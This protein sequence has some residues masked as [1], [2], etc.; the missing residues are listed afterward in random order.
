VST[1]NDQ[2]AIRLDEVAQILEEQ[3]ANPFRVRAYRRGAI[4]SGYCH[5]RSTSC[6][7]KAGCRRSSPSRAS[8]RAWPAPFATSS[9]P[10]GSTCSSD[11]GRRRPGN[12]PRHRSGHR[13]ENGRAPASRPRH[14]NA[15]GSRGCRHDGRLETLE[16]LV[17]SGWPGSG[18]RWR[19]TRSRYVRLPSRRLSNRPSPNCWTSTSSTDPSRTPAPCGW[20]HHA[21]STRGRGVAAHPAHAPRPSPLHGALLQHASRAPARH[22]T[23]LGRGVPRRW[24]G[25]GQWTVITAH[26]GRSPTVGSSGAASRVRAVLRP[27]GGWGG[28]LTPP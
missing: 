16:G 21:G 14:R 28:P 7:T 1:I 8:A 24:P 3:G 19:K 25:S 12:A 13:A 10:G 6:S 2:V 4:R 5:D 18:S 23:R 26:F 15:R 17:R 11:S 27:K 20:W 9:K 22:D